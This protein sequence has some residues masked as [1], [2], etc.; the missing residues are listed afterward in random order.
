MIHEAGFDDTFYYF[1]NERQ[2]RDD[3]ND[4]AAAAAQLT[5]GLLHYSNLTLCQCPSVCHQDKRCNSSSCIN[6]DNVY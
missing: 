1:G 4:A 6:D 2:I 3:D 5:V